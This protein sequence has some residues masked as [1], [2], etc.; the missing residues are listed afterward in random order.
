MSK[1][2]KMGKLQGSRLWFGY[3]TP[4]PVPFCWA[5]LA[6]ELVGM[7]LSQAHS[8]PPH[9]KSIITFG[10]QLCTRAISPSP[11]HL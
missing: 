4:L 7:G 9:Q 11:F 3:H 2:T 5:L 1:G 8:P 10:K 6:V